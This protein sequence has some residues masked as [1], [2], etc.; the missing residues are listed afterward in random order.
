[1]VAKIH[2][3]SARKTLHARRCTQDA[4][5]KTLRVLLYLFAR[6]ETIGLLGAG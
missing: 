5:R 2:I 3:E 6:D 1:V 4:A